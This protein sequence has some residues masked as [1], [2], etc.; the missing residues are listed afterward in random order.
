M[1]NLNG[2]YDIKV[3]EIVFSGHDNLGFFED[4]SVFI[5]NPHNDTYDSTHS[6]YECCNA[7]IKKLQVGTQ[8]IEYATA[9]IYTLDRQLIN[10][11]TVLD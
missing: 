9:Y 6:L 7:F 4:K 5:Y 11:F 2:Y 1:L 8:V 3:V 10:Q